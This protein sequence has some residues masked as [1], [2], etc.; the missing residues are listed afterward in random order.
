MRDF[1]NIPITDKEVANKSSAINTKRFA[2]FSTTEK[3]SPK[4]KEWP[5]NS[6][7]LVPYDNL[8]NPIRDIL[9]KAYR[10]IRHAEIKSF[11]Y[12]GFNLGKSERRNCPSPQLRFSEKFI[13]FENKRGKTVIDI[14][15]N[16]V[17]TLGL[18]QGRRLERISSKP[19]LGMKEALEAYKKSNKELRIK[20]DELEVMLDI[21]HS[22]PSASMEEYNVLLSKGIKARRDERLAYLKEELKIDPIKSGFN[23]PD[24]IKL[25][26]KNLEKLMN[27]LQNDCC[28]ERWKEILADH[29]WT[30][31]EWQAKCEKKKIKSLF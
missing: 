3:T 17:F 25:S 26:F 12:D 29:G 24:P 21:K 9:K 13:E 4:M 14:A 23:P 22:H 7:E 18:E 15:L 8:I 5:S 16:I 30:Y 28:A 27:L 20:T 10:F 11:E 6:Y 1:L 19:I 31:D 2:I